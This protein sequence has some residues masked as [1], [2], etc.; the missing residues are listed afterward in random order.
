M[1]KGFTEKYRVSVH[2]HETRPA[3][4][5][6]YQSWDSILHGVLETEVR[7]TFPIVALHSLGDAFELQ[8]VDIYN[9]APLF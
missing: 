3:T 8:K 4:F 6:N 9:R 7:V 2:T 5:V 1:G